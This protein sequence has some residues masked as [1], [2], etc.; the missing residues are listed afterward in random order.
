MGVQLMRAAIIEN[1]V[2]ANIVLAAKPSDFG[3]IEC[4][5]DVAIGWSYDGE[6]FSA[7]SATPGAGPT[8][9]DVKD[10]AQSL[11]VAFC[12]EWKQRNLTARAAELAMK[13]KENWTAEEQAEVATGQAVW[14]RIKAIRAA[15]DALEAIDPIPP[16]YL[17][18]LAAVSI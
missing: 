2:V 6:A 1:G 7:P 11:I 4:G 15:S 5:E 13:G 3:A 14:D 17:S 8:V 18:L 10:G 16:N 9:A 12:P